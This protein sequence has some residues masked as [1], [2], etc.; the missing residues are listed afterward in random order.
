MT[1]AQPALPFNLPA[2]VHIHESELRTERVRLRQWT[3]ADFEPFAALNCD[4]QVMRHFPALLSREQSDAHASRMRALI[5]ERGWGFWATDWLQQDGSAP[6]FI[7]FVGMHVPIAELPFSPCVEIGWRLARPFWGK[8]LASEAAR[9]AMRAGFE[10]LK[11]PEI[12]SFTSREN[13]RSRAVMQRLGMHSRPEDHF[14]HPA[15]PEGH[16]VRPH[17]LYR[18]TREEWLAQAHQP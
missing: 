11:L 12:V 5:E 16:P 13:L 4:P 18:I 1:P 10:A 7:G 3:K 9:L 15:V 6:Q 17:C 8:G 14:D 2:H